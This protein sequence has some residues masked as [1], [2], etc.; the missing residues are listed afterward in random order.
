MLFVTPLNFPETIFLTFEGIMLSSK[1]KKWN[2]NHLSHSFI[3]ISEFVQGCKKMTLL[4]TIVKEN[5]HYGN[6]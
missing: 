4:E 1:R 6:G 3:W 5:Q 2:L